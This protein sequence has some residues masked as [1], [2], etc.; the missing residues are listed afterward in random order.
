MKVE[1]STHHYYASSRERHYSHP[2]IQAFS[3]PKY[4]WINQQLDIKGKTVLDVGSGNGYFAQHFEKDCQ[5]TALDLSDN[6]LQYNPA[7]NKQ[8]GSAYEIPFAD[9]SFDIVFCS[10][11]LHH[12]DKPEDAVKEMARVARKHVIINEPNRNNPIIFFGAL[13]IPHERRAVYSSRKYLAGMIKAAGL[14][15]KKHTYLGGFVMPNGTPAFMLKAAM[16]ET[17]LPF[18]FFQLFITENVESSEGN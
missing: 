2:T 15:I 17:Q 9:N 5:L 8:V 11:L 4:R 3:L 16:P 7:S 10:N 14:N 1:K 13:L 6:Q 18:S 12:L